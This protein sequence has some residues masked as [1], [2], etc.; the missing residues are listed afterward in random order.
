MKTP[1]AIQQ[2]K[3]AKIRASLKR[4]RI[5]HHLK[6]AG[7]T[8]LYGGLY[9]AGIISTLYAQQWHTD[10]TDAIR[11]TAPAQVV[12]QAQPVPKAPAATK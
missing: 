8:A 1:K 10:Y 7:K 9:A 2:N 3:L 11:A 12:V 6:I 4:A 5:G